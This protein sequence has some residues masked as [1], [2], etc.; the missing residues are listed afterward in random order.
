MRGTVED[1]L[2]PPVGGG[3]EL[4][5]LRT[6]ENEGHPRIPSSAAEAAGS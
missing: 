4:A 1:G 6:P 2:P 5:T 3:R